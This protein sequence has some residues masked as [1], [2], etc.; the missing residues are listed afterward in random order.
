MPVSEATQ[1]PSSPREG[2]AMAAVGRWTNRPEAPSIIFLIL[3]TALIS[4]TTSGFFTTTALLTVLV[5]AVP[6]ALIGLA[7]NQ[8][9]I[10]GEIDISVGSAL[11][12]L[13][14]VYYGVEGVTEQPW[15]AL[16]VTIAAGGLIGA[17][18][19][20][21]TV[22]AR[23]PSIM[24]TLGALMILRGGLLLSARNISIYAH[25][26]T[27]MFG[28]GDLLGVPVELWICLAVFLA[29]ELAGRLSYW[30][31]HVYA[32]GGNERAARDMGIPI[33]RVKLIAFI[34]TGAATALAAV[35]IVGQVAGMAATVGGGFELKA[36]AAVVLGGTSLAGGR[37][38]N[39]APVVGAVLL[40]LI[41]NASALH[42]IPPS[43]DLLTLGIILLG[44]ISFVG[45]RQRLSHRAGRR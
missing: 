24:V 42:R 13:C 30:G 44:A 22:Y 19:G 29:F 17:V 43:F 12:V 21:V 40:S 27:R 6:V 35:V 41:L 25:D 9:I 4:F 39:L 3:F 20:I 2:G 10:A 28:H 18:N 26:R 37:G 5:Q 45:L 34:A 7:M 1:H 36:I 11:G 38:S 15:L 32:V 8:V 14:F 16:L 33:E 23:I 31:R